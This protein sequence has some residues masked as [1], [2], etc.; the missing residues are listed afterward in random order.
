MKGRV[1][2]DLVGSYDPYW[3]TTCVRREGFER[4]LEPPANDE[5]FIDEL[6]VFIGLRPIP[7]EAPTYSIHWLVDALMAGPMKL[8]AIAR[9]MKRRDDQICRDLGKLA[10]RGLVRRVRKKKVKGLWQLTK[11]AQLERRIMCYNAS[12]EQP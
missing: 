3:K 12:Q 7:P 9:Q 4:R 10:K 5:D 11:K 2:A 1:L 8:E 6:R